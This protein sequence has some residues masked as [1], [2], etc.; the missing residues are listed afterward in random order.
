MIRLLCFH[1]D[2]LAREIEEGQP[3]EQD[4]LKRLIGDYDHVD[5]LL[6]SAKGLEEGWS[7]LSSKSVGGSERGRLNQRQVEKS[8]RSRES[9]EDGKEAGPRKMESGRNREDR[10][11]TEKEKEDVCCRSKPKC[12]H[13]RESSESTNWDKTKMAAAQ[14][15]KVERSDTETC[16]CG[17]DRKLCKKCAKKTTSPPSA[18]STPKSPER[19][20]KSPDRAHGSPGGIPK[21]PERTKSTETVPKV[22]PKK[23]KHH[24]CCHDVVKK[25]DEKRCDCKVVQCKAMDNLCEII[26]KVN[27]CALSLLH[28]N[29]L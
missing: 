15:R 16:V 14:T 24:V 7:R 3:G 25:V 18:Q 9:S 21:S 13:G 11:K 26:I 10:S 8:G 28:K 6:K 27:E 19:V 5:E 1:R 12:V 22:S 17:L 20:R 23:Q 4:T 29:E 2:K